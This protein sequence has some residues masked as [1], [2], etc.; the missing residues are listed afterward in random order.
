MSEL[1]SGRRI[2]VV[3][4]EMLILMMIEGILED[5]GCKSVTGAATV[6]KAVALIEA[7][8]FDAAMLDMNLGGEDSSR[9]ADALSE[10]GVPF[11]Y[12]TGND[13]CGRSAD[14][15]DH[16]VLYKPY[17]ESDLIAAI[18]QLLS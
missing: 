8:T 3:E 7:E 15:R 13:R 18:T 11:I 1:L 14:S 10:R 9:V 12:S 17:Q 4:D 2:L 6:K 16:A 5:L